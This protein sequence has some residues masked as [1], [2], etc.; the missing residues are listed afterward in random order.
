M[1]ERDCLFAIKQI[2]TRG[3]KKKRNKQYNKVIKRE[4]V[5]FQMRCSFLMAR[6]LHGL[7]RVLRALCDA[8]D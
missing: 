6:V 4:A 2:K 1:K 8:F 7:G 3:F 5:F